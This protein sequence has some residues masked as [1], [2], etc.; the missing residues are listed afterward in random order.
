MSAI[1]ACNHY[2]LYNHL[3]LLYK[4]HYYYSTW[5]GEWVLKYTE[6]F[7]LKEALTFENTLV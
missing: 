1:S 7:T 4:S 5:H 2:V 3:W 6:S